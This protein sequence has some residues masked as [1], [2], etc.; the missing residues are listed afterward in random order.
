MPKRLS[1]EELESMA[2][3]GAIVK[4][5]TAPTPTPAGHSDEVAA[6]QKSQLEHL[7]FMMASTQAN[8][9]QVLIRTLLE[10]I[11]TIPSEKE[12]LRALTAVLTEV[13]QA[14]PRQQEF[15]PFSFDIRRDSEGFLES[16][17]MTPKT[18]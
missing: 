6:M 17:D 14:I 11:K 13:L 4:F 15:T 16:I 9:L 12:E 18:H 10:N 8:E 3:G 5:P 7:S 1:K 2:A